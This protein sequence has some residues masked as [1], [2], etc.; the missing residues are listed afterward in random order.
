M[1]IDTT[2]MSIVV[3]D[4]AT[5]GG[6]TLLRN[7]IEDPSPQLGGNLDLNSYDLFTENADTAENIDIIAGNST[8]GIGGSITLQTGAGGTDGGSV[9]I[10]SNV[11]GTGD[12]GR[13]IFACPEDA[14]VVIGS[15]D[16]SGFSA[17]LKFAS[18]SHA[19]PPGGT[20]YDEVG[21]TD[22]Y[23]R[24]AAPTG[25]AAGQNVDYTLPYPGPTEDGEVLQSTTA[26]VMSWAPPA[27]LGE[28]TVAGLPSAA[29]HQNSYA[30]A[31]DAVGGRTV[32]RS[33]GT[34]WEIVVVLGGA[35]S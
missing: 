4:G 20:A 1:T 5:P 8:V 6:F 34:I 7:V 33:N 28:F 26:G 21:K 13:I 17:G 35:V 18:E 3:H 16:T 29:T 30:V 10:N 24:L 9:F 31:T 27:D 2:R 22:R 11:S 19:E 23:V 15:R 32:V 25:L 12:H 14:D